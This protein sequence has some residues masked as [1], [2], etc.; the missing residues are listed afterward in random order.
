MIV[1]VAVDVKYRQSKELLV[2]VEDRVRG[3]ITRYLEGT[4]YAFIGR[5]KQPES[6]SEK[7]ETG[8][9]RSWSELDDLYACTVVVPTTSTE[10]QVLD[11]LRTTF[12]EINVHRRGSSLKDPSAFRFD[13]TR[14]IGTLK[15]TIDPEPPDSLSQQRFEVQVRTAFEHAW[16]VAT[17][18]LVYKCDRIEW[19]RLRLIPNLRRQPN[20]LTI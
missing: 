9:Y 2:E 17:H 14:F 6:L 19:R 11:Y 20:S 16:A 7:I 3:A 10:P 15:P 13:S 4:G 1:P 18:R 5:R 12:R 8:R